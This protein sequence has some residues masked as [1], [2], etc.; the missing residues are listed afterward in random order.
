MPRDND[1]E[2][3]VERVDPLVGSIFDKRFRVEE[4]IAVGGFGAIYRAT[5]IKSGHQIALKVLLPQLAQDLG[6][7]ARFRREGDTLTALRNP[8][9]INAY[10]LGQAADHTLFIT[11]ELLYGESLF[12]RYKANGPFEWK[13]MVR[14]ARQVCESLEEAH[15]RGI[16]HRDLKP[17]NIHLEKHGDD[18]DYV[19]VLDFGIAKILGGGGADI[20]NAGQMIGTLDYMSPEQMVGGKVT[21]Q[22]DLYT[23]GI[24]MYEMIAG[25]TPFPQAMT[26]AQALSAVMK[27]KPNAL[28]LRAPVPEEL[29]RI[30]MR[31]LE[32]DTSVR[33]QTVGELRAD[34]ER[35]VAGTAQDRARGVETKPIERFDEATQ[36]TPPPVMF[37]R[38]APDFEDTQFTPPPE[39]L[40]AE[41]RPDWTGEA[42]TAG[43]PSVHLLAQARRAKRPSGEQTQFTP[44]PEQILAELRTTPRLEQPPEW[45]DDDEHVPTT[46]RRPDG[47]PGPRVTS[48]TVPRSTAEHQNVTKV[49]RVSDIEGALSRAS[50]E[51]EGFTTAIPR[52]RSSTADNERVTKVARLADLA[53]SA[54]AGGPRE[55]SDRAATVP[56]DLKDRAVTTPRE[57]GRDQIARTATDFAD[58]HEVPTMSR[59][60]YARA[61]TLHVRVVPGGQAAQPSDRDMTMPRRVPPG[62]D[63]DSGLE[64][65]TPPFPRVDDGSAAAPPARRAE[66]SPRK[67]ETIPPPI[68]VS[69]RKQPSSPPPASRSGSRTAPPPSVLTPPRALSPQDQALRVFPPQPQAPVP[70]RTMTPQQPPRVFPPQQPAVPRTF[71]PQ[72]QAP[73]LPRTFTPQQAAALPPNAPAPPVSTHGSLPRQLATPLP[74]L[75]AAP[76]SQQPVQPYPTSP[77]AYGQPPRGFDMGKIAARDALLRRWI[78]IA[79]FILAA[80]VGII[81]ATQL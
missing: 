11:M 81:L 4:R 39:R 36:F 21:G 1:V 46:N 19:K 73:A 52:N 65:I 24:V 16:V 74:Q 61:A 26:A 63:E 37:D 5:H 23:L 2:T 45:T 33:Y 78:W 55:A 28:Y 50:D 70:S 20:T 18:L 58:A 41:T 8:H 56:R 75:A 64:M 72:Q 44:P 14:I 31:C 77:G 68:P 34:L 12:E 35:L 80:I 67:G 15:A 27:T 53:A 60:D 47:A 32:R 9:T 71:T 76:F 38:Q 10:E 7:V 6:I 3:S 59:D 22:S 48:A 43:A 40:V 62:R 49:A 54:R 30:V 13:R 57:P 25:C 42:T 79:A 51:P 17:T 69:A 29:D 66:S